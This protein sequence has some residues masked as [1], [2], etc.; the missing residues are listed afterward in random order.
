M[1]LKAKIRKAFI[2][3]KKT[4]FIAETHDHIYVRYILTVVTKTTKYFMG[5]PLSNLT[6]VNSNI[7]FTR[8]VC[9]A[10]SAKYSKILTEPT[11]DSEPK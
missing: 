6:H 2:W 1:D 11:R 9:A 7:F 3:K 4:L 8:Y 10:I 5:K